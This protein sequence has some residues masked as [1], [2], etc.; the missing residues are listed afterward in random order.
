MSRL[1]DWSKAYYKCDKCDQK[2]EYGTLLI[3][4]VWDGKDEHRCLDC[5]KD[6][7]EVHR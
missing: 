1:H 2:A 3:A 6:F 7:L 4:V 5:F